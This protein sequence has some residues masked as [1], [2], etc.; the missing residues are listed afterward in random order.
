MRMVDAVALAPG[1]TVLEVGPGRG[2]L[3]RLLVQRA[4]VV[5]V[6]VDAQLAHELRRTFAA[7]G[8]QV[9]ERD[10][11]SI[12]LDE[13][14]AQ[15]APPPPE[16]WV[17]VSNLPYNISKPFASRLVHERASVRRAVLTFQR[18]VA[19]R[20]TAAHGT[21][22]YGPLTVL[23]GAAYRIERLF[24]LPPGAFFPAPRVDSTVTRWVP[25]ED[26]ALEPEEERALRAC[27]AACFAMRRR[28]L[29][30][31]LRAAL[32]DP[33]RAAELLERAGIDGA[34]RAEEVDAQTYRRLAALWPVA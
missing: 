2:A 15:A 5:A 7:S 8:L 24:D 16:R 25:R 20:L 34:R 11:L 31:N 1:E 21:R 6:E 32:R 26:R 17:V 22:A 33:A 4:P 27:L 30:N 29:F 9:I 12:G 10:I 23:A 18:E 13:L 14:A 28:T 3:T 19:E